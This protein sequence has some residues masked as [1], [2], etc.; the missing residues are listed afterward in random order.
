MNVAAALVPDKRGA[1]QS[2]H[3]PHRSAH[4]RGWMQP[5]PAWKRLPGRKGRPSCMPCGGVAC[6]GWLEKHYAAK[7]NAHN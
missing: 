3:E 5:S 6:L 1:A 4:T 2:C 7:K